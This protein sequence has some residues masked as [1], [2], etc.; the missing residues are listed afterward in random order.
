MPFGFSIA[1]IPALGRQ[2]WFQSST[3]LYKLSEHLNDPEDWA[4][5]AGGLTPVSIR[6][7]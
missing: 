1:T 5:F 4:Q 3:H 2:K 7:K 6:N